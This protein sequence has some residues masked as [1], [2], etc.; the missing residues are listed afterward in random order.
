MQPGDKKLTRINLYNYRIKEINFGKLRVYFFLG[1]GIVL[2]LFFNFI[3]YSYYEIHIIHQDTRNAFLTTNINMIDN[4]LKPIREFDKKV[5][6]I[7]KQVRLLQVVEDKRDDTVT[8]FQQLGEVTPEQV[9]YKQITWN[10]MMCQLTGTASSPLY[11]A[12]LLDKLRD[13]KGIFNNPELVSNNLGADGS[14]DFMITVQIKP[15]LVAV[16]DGKS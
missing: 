7:R 1:I 4:K 3:I 13:K 9:Y 11:L 16:P 14:Y 8:F 10:G 2:S 5:E 6:L 15:N 12:S